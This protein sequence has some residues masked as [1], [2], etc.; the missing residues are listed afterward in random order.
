MFKINSLNNYLFFSMFLPSIF[1]FLVGCGGSGNDTGDSPPST[2]TD[3]PPTINIIS[4]TNTAVIMEGTYTILTATADDIEDGNLSNNVLWH[5]DRDGDLGSGENLSVLLTSGTHIITASI[6]DS[7]N[8][9]TSKSLTIRINQTPT[10]SA[11][12][13]QTV[14][15]NI[16]VEIA[17]TAQDN[18]GNI[19]SYLWQQTSGN[20]INLN[21]SDQ[22]IASFTAPTLSSNEASRILTFEITTTDNDGAINQDSVSITITKSVNT[23][24][25]TLTINPGDLFTVAFEQ[26][27]ANDTLCLNDGR[28]QQAMDIPSNINVRA[29]HDGMAELDGGGTLGL[30][31]KGGLL[32]MKG[33]NS[34]ARG[35]R[36]HHASTYADACAIK[37]NNNTMRLMSC[38]H[39]GTYKHSIPVAI[40]GSGHLIEDSWFFGEGRYVIMCYRGNNITIR[41]NV[42]RWDKTIAGE[43]NE[44]NASM[45]NYSCSDMIWENNISLDYG[46]PETHMVY[47]GDICMSTTGET[48]NHRVQYLGN[49]VVNHA[50]D[51]G[52]NRAFRA[53]QKGTTPSTDI[54]IKDFYVK[55]A[56]L[57]IAVNP[58]YE[59]TVISHCTMINVTSN[60]SV[61]G[62]LVECNGDADVSVRYINGVKTTEP[63]F[64]FAH[65]TLIKRDM[66]ANNERQSDWCLTDLSLAEYLLN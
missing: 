10:V 8:Q 29:V 65:E 34:S 53:D 60:G 56:H 32:T 11:G 17:A 21:N 59:N 63:L 54:T 51:T 40:S 41:R 24:D 12:E 38:S 57:G 23:D 2:N 37:G 9:S 6:S 50:A 62:S 16:Q 52:N 46:V 61:D 27:S 5:S 35:L 49:I 48:Q 22:S 20:T 3:T 4:P 31:W 28:Y 55:D 25:C 15:E 19:V 33:E 18:D 26:L 58:L 1:I 13:D 42:I 30:D 36:V 44:P 43:S 47:C 39:G 7:K 64:P 66:C 14:N 45:S